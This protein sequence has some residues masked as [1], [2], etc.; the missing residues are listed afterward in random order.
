MPQKKFRWF[1]WPGILILMV[2]CA[3]ITGDDDDEVPIPAPRSY[4]GTLKSE[5][6]GYQRPKIEMRVTGTM[7]NVR[8]SPTLAGSVIA[9]AQRGTPFV[10]VH[11]KG[12]W[13]AAEMADGTLGWM[14]RDYVEPD[15][16]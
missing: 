11:Q 14:H 8:A 16:R 1:S 4:T 5:A 7:V 2:G 3:I 9:Q 13:V 10:A 6:S 15:K 12:D